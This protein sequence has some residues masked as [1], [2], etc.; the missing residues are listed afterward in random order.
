MTTYALSAAPEDFVS[1]LALRLLAM[2]LPTVGI[3]LGS[4]VSSL[5]GFNQYL[6]I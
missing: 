5:V 1:V 4:T 2:E 3:D 6:L